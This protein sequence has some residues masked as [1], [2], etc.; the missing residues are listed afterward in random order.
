MIIMN[1]FIIILTQI[2][3]EILH[4]CLCLINLLHFELNSSWV[5]VLNKDAVLQVQEG[6]GLQVHLN[7][8]TNSKYIPIE[9]CKKIMSFQ[10]ALMFFI[11]A[12]FQIKFI[13]DK[14][15]S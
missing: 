14:K 1:R 7:C 3:R 5:G 6:H 9:A 11:P 4:L 2:F 8:L 15:D 13:Q 10:V 12:D